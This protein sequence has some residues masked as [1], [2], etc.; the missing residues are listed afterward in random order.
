MTPNGIYIK[1]AIPKVKY[2]DIRA[3]G[4]SAPRPTGMCPTQLFPLTEVPHTGGSSLRLSLAN[5]LAPL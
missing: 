5:H 1:S 3:V 2:E 4:I